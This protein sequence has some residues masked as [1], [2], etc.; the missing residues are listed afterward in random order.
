MLTNCN[1]YKNPGISKAFRPFFLRNQ[2]LVHA[3][4]SIVSTPIFPPVG[5]LVGQPAFRA[6]SGLNDSD[7]L[8]KRE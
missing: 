5:Q 6:E 8:M 1:R 7:K 2:Q 4:R 3:I